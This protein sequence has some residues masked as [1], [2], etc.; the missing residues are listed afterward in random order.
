ME[1][2]YHYT[3]VLEALNDLNKKGFTVDFNLH[4]ERIIRNPNQ[5]EIKHI[6]RYEGDTDPGEEATVYGIESNS[7]ERGVFVS[8]YSANSNDE[9]DQVVQNIRIQ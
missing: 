3:N 7:G 1:P 5:F 2:T 6:Y 8:G 9:V 4:K